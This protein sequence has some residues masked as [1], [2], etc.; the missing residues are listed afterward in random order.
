MSTP[1]GVSHE[2]AVVHEAESAAATE[3]ITGA[4]AVVLAILGLIGVLSGVFAAVSTIAVGVALAVAGSAL[5]TH[6]GKTLRTNDLVYERHEGE[7]GMRMEALAAVA[8]VVLGI[9]A[10]IGV[11]ALTLL[12][13]A[14]IVLGG[15]LLMVGGSAARVESLMRSEVVSGSRGMLEHAP[16]VATGSDLLVGVGAVV[17]GILGL[18]GHNPQTLTL[19]AMLGI[20]AAVLLNGSTIAARLFGLVS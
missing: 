1:I 5:A 14:A 12:P 17:L 11:S 16:Y 2:H 20:G 3:S 15:A 19:I 10:L 6:Y 13:V 4:I 9:L 18:S 7:R 8:G